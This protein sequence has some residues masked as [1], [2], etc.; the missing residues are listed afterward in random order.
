MICWI[1]TIYST[2]ASIRK[3]VV[4]VMVGLTLNS[5]FTDK[6]TKTALDLRPVKTFCYKFNAHPASMKILYHHRTASKDG[7]A[8][9]IE[10]MIEAMRSLGH[11]VRV[12][13]PTIGGQADKQGEMGGEV[14]W[15]HKLKVALPRAVYELLE[16]A[17]SLVAY[18]QLVK[19]AKDFKPDLI[20]ERYNL[21]LLSGTLLKRKLRIPLLLEVNS[22]LVE[23]RL[24][25]SG[26][27]SL[28]RLAHWSEGTAWRSADFVLPVT[29]V[30]ANHVKAYGVPPDRIAV[31][32]NGINEAHFVSAPASQEAKA[33]LGLQGKLVL[34]FT[35]FV[36]DWHGVDRVIT[37]MAGPQAP[38]NTHLLV[39]GDGPI[40][41]E[42]EALA[43]SLGLAQ[44]LAFT[45]V[46]DRHRVPEHVAA[47]DVA[48]QPAVTAYASPLKLM[49]YLV[50]GK[51]IVA[52]REPNLLEVLTD[53]DNALLFD[54]TTTGSFESALT[55][56]CTN[57]DLRRRLAIGA[58]ST[59]V[60]LDLTWLGN[61]KKVVDLSLRVRHEI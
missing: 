54:D 56:L 28:V 49:E 2:I 17:Y 19:A 48:L 14:G 13:A 45:G 3:Q 46:I 39:V 24:K 38:V 10:E 57:E 37:W 5:F 33:R 1:H 29:H 35:G 31:I 32:P 53:G 6:K 18:R 43:A 40:R 44:R 58:R 41:A 15:V 22:P 42:L 36:R 50:L 34:G 61:A 55:Q 7:Q 51:A 8:V 47:F 59:I 60:R 23:E 12:V 26:G 52:P 21:F 11:E 9:H 16:L 27:L 20:Y 4:V 30:L 25:H